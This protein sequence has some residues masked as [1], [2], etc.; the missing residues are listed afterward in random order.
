MLVKS[1]RSAR[2]VGAGNI[3]VV[4]TCRLAISTYRTPLTVRCVVMRHLASKSSRENAPERPGKSSDT[5][6]KSREHFIVDVARS[7]RHVTRSCCCMR[8]LHGTAVFSSAAPL[9]WGVGFSNLPQSRGVTMQR[10]CVAPVALRL[11]RPG[12]ARAGSVSSAVEDRLKGTD[13]S[14][15]AVA[16]RAGAAAALAPAGLRQL[17]TVPGSCTCPL[18]SF[19]TVRAART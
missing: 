8:A 16:D 11:S 13:S 12:E 6:E 3:L 2:P 19:P 7:F 5:S 18:R 1:F 9:R 4:F 15:S 17:A 10:H 14:S